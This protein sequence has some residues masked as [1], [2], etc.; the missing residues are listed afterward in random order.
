[1]SRDDVAGVFLSSTWLDLHTERKE[2]LDELRGMRAVDWVAM[3][4]FGSDTRPPAKTSL[5]HLD[6]CKY[7]V[8]VV[9]QR[10]G[11]GITEQEYEYAYNVRKITCLIYLFSGTPDQPLKDADG[12]PLVVDEKDRR[13]L[14]RFKKR[15]REAHTPT[16]FA[17]LPKLIARVAVDLGNQ[18]LADLALPEK[19]NKLPYLVNREPQADPIETSTRS[20]LK[21][22]EPRASIFLVSGALRD[23]HSGLLQRY[24][25]FQLP[26]LFLANKRDGIPREDPIVVTWPVV[27]GVKERIAKLQGELNERLGL[28]YDAPDADTH[29]SLAGLGQPR[30]FVS[31]LQ[32]A[33]WCAEE[34][35]VIAQWLRFWQGARGSAGAPLAVFLCV[36]FGRTLSP[37]WMERLQDMGARRQLDKTLKQVRGWDQ[38][39]PLPPLKAVTAP[40]AMA[41]A[42]SKELLEQKIDP[43]VVKSAINA[44]YQKVGERPMDE[45]IEPLQE[46]VRRAWVAGRRSA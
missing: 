45:V 21:E 15:L 3:E 39:K 14:A 8:G 46:S 28:P 29:R 18:L 24:Q 23:C 20:A 5:A 26:N 40:D 33:N 42:D 35:E 11:S 9:G 31:Y 4:H 43:G 2:L 16:D 38:V 7:Y 10:Y 32:M 27:G 12:N 41:W 44:L 17:S 13:E 6:R 22:Q 30:A 37:S 1:M 25:Y 36:Q 19:L 34:P